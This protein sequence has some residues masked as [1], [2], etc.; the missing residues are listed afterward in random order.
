MNL[1]EKFFYNHAGFSYDPKTE[2]PEQG[3]ARCA[4]LLAKA[5]EFAI[6]ES[7]RF[8]WMPD[9]EICAACMHCAVLDAEPC[10]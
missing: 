2:T 7:I 4:K 1:R 9:D 8:E 3:R 5:E 10:T 6:E